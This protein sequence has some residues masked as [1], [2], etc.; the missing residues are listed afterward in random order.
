[1][2]AF[3]GKADMVRTYFINAQHEQWRL[4]LEAFQ[5]SV[6]RI[7]STYSAAMPLS[8]NSFFAFLFLV[9]CVNPMPRSTLG[10]LVN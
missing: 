10:A 9:K 4:I 1:M 7:E 8:A 3:G 5:S 6:R 2:S